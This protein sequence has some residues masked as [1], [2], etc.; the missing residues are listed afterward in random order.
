MRIQLERAK[1]IGEKIGLNDDKGYL[2]AIALALIIISALLAG[3]YLIYKPTPEGYS[4]IY[5]LDAQNN[6]ENYPQ[7]LVANQNSTFTVPVA[8]VNNM[9]WTVQYQVLVKITDNLDSSPVNVQ[10]TGT[11]NI[12][13][14]NG[15]TWKN[16]V[17][18]TENQV[19]NYSVV[20]ELYTF[21]PADGGSYQFT[22]NICVLPIQ[23]VSQA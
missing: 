10:P 9:G 4:T 20:F 6:A 16:S 14:K 23:V 22:Y 19:G 2:V 21:N 17:S 1:N 18:V 12:T 11:Y 8:V 15:Q 13:L 5:L 3:Y 7:V